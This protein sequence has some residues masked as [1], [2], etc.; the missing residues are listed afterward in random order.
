MARRMV[1][2][3]RRGLDGRGRLLLVRGPGGRRDQILRIPDWALRNRER[4]YGTA[5]RAGMRRIRRAGRGARPGGEGQR[6]ADKGHPGHGGIE[7]G[8]SDLRQGAHRALQIS[9]HRGVQ[10]R[11][12]QDRQRQDSAQQAVKKTGAGDESFPGNDGK[13][14]IPPRFHR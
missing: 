3:R 11:I 1:S 13:F 12:A 6:R 2:H 14:R 9:P 5:L 4:H 10:G 8:D 7:K